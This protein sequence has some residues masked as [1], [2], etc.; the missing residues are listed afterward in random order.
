MTS[1]SRVRLS[2]Q[3]R[4]EQLLDLGVSMFA[5]RNVEELSIDEVAEAAGVSRGLLYHYFPG[6]Q[7][8]RDAV[9]RR[10]AEEF[11]V[12]TAASDAPDPMERLSTTVVN[13]VDFVDANHDAYLSLVRAAAGGDP[14]MK[15]VYDDA[16]SALAERILDLGVLDLVPDSEAVRLLVRG[17]QALAEEIVLAWKAPGGPDDRNAVS[18]A[19]VVAMLTDSIA[20]ILLTATPAE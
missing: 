9:V 16:R 4:R 2:P 17:W 5:H 12:A 20:A 18:K 1:R 6:L 7:G 8:F 10:V 15:K 19:D 3:E 13:Y 11:V 14:G